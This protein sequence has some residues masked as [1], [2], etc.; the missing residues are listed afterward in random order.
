MLHSYFHSDEE[1]NRVIN[2]PQ[3]EKI[4]E[5]RL[6]ASKLDK[7]SAVGLYNVIVEFN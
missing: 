4:K 2:L 1:Y 5:L 3:K 6:I 7:T